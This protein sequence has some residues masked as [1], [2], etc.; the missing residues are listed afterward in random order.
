MNVDPLFLLMFFLVPV[1]A[2]L[3]SWAVARR[4]DP[5]RVAARRVGLLALGAS[6][7]AGAVWF[8][9]VLAYSLNDTGPEYYGF[10]TYM[11]YRRTFFFP[12]SRL[13][14]RMYGLWLAYALLPVMLVLLR[15]VLRD[16]GRRVSHWLLPLVAGSVLLPAIVPSLLPRSEFG[17]DEVFFPYA[18]PE[19]STTPTQ[20]PRVCF[21]YGTQDESDVTL[22][23]ENAPKL[24][25]RLRKSPQADSLQ[26][27]DAPDDERASAYDLADELNR[28]GHQPYEVPTELDF[29]GVAIEDAC[30]VPLGAAGGP[31]PT[32]ICTSAPTPA[33]PR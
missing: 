7:A 8:V 11:Q 6:F 28:Q 30:W 22:Q 15:A 13:E 17:K 14:G 16:R 25:L 20:G 33:L 9:D 4:L 3:V 19:P 2:G 26:E 31:P 21:A 5:G 32:D 10:S 12:G 1:A 18:P 23:A 27:V 24:C 29:P